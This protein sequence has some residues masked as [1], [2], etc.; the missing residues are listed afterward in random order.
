[1]QIDKLSDKWLFE[2]HAKQTIRAWLRQLRYF[3]FKRAWGG[4]ANDGDEFQTAFLFT[5]KPDLI[6]KL[7]QLGLTLNTIPD[8]FPA[9]VIGQPNTA[10]EFEKFK[11]KIKKFPDLA[12]PGHSTIFGY[13]VFIWVHDNSIHITLSGT[14]D[15]NHYE[16][17]EEDFKICLELEKHFDRLG[18]LAI[19]D[20]SLEKSVCC[21][22]QAKYP[23]L[24]G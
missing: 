16:V 17:T 2:R 15:N 4:Q 19:I 10:D 11:N 6:H 12:Q 14:K 7:G 24:Y 3:Y 8:N 5:D 23:E 22:S 9:P 18:W 21:I 1:M 20:Q 13:K